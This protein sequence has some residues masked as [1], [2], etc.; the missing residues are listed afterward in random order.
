MEE[1]GVNFRLERHHF[2][3]LSVTQLRFYFSNIPSV[4]MARS[5]TA[6]HTEN[7]G[8]HTVQEFLVETQ[9]VF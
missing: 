4:S 1:K 9:I 5:G 3:N 6:H 7:E 2:D 8:L